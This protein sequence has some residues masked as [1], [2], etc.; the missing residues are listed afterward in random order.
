M[1]D[2]LVLTPMR[3]EASAARRGAEFATILRTGIGPKR[4]RRS[5]ATLAAKKP[6]GAVIVLGLCGGLHSDLSPGDV[7]VATDVRSADGTVNTN[8]PGS[9]ILATEVAHAGFPVKTGPI[10]TN[11]RI[12]NGRTR[13]ELARNESVAVD[14]ESAWLVNELQENIPGPICVVRVVSDAPGSEIWSLR[15][16]QNLK[17]ARHL[18]TQLMPSLERWASITGSCKQ[19]VHQP[20]NLKFDKS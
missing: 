18:L 5:G 4:S 10:I 7:I 6:T 14:M 1:S 11:D 3:L 9:E 19:R 15:T 8:I 2:L 12:A 13:S 16:P 17:H 20:Q